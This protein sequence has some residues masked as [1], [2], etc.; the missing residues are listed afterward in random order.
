MSRAI[1][2]PLIRT[3]GKS[4]KRVPKK[5]APMPSIIRPVLPPIHN[6]RLVDSALGM[7]PTTPINVTAE[8]GQEEV[9]Q[10]PLHSVAS[11]KKFE[12]ALL[13]EPATSRSSA[14]LDL[15]PNLNSGDPESVLDDILKRFPWDNE[16]MVSID[17]RVY[18]ILT[19]A[20]FTL[21]RDSYQSGQMSPLFFKALA[22]SFKIMPPGDREL[23]TIVVKLLYKMSRISDFDSMFLQCQLIKKLI[24]IAFTQ[25]GEISL[26]SAAILRYISANKENAEEILKYDTLKLICKAL[27]TSIQREK[28]KP[29]YALYSYQVIS[30][31]AQLY[32]HIK[33]FTLICRFSLPLYLLDIVTIYMNDIGIQAAIS[34]ALSLMMLEKD[35]VEVLEGEDLTPFF[36]LMQSKTPKIIESAALALA[37]AMNISDLIIDGV[38]EVSMPLGLTQ[39]CEMLKLPINIQLKVSV[40]RCLSKA[41]QLQNG[42]NPILLYLNTLIPLLETPID[43]LE[44]WSNEEMV[45]ANVLIILKNGA[46]VDNERISGLMKGRMD[47]LMH[48]GIIDYVIDLMRVLMK[49]EEGK[50]V[51]REVSEIEEVK[52]C[53]GEIE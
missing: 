50:E 21:I 28:F 46:I 49:T 19:Q 10:L 3:P 5:N 29:D 48:Y 25:Y 53:L 24:D 1:V 27:N 43:D 20:L 51:C 14:L 41:S 12:E 35:C 16:S 6:R 2:Q 9:V 37:N 39:L 8:E 30:L 42:I 36:I 17:F 7:R 31:F 11:M 22:I 38:C 33:D 45:V 23:L 13:D 18:H 44:T 26:Y 40:L 32:D 34:K 15:I 52:M 4:P 47:S